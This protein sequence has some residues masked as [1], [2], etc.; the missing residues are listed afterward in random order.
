[1]T[2]ERWQR[3]KEVFQSA[4]ERQPQD[5]GAFLAAETAGDRE[6]RR[7]VE[8]MLRHAS[9]AG[10]LDRPA[11]DGL[12]FD[13]QLAVG[14]R[15]G[16]YEIL[17]EAGAGGMGRVYKA[18]DTRLGRM[19]AI[20]VL[21]AEFSDRFQSEARAISALNHPHVCGLHDIGEQDG[22]AY[23]VMEYVEGE[24]LAAC[25][26]RGPL[27]VEEVLRY[28]EEIAD[29]LAAAHAQGIVH[30]DLKPDNIMIT[31]SGAKVLDFGVARMAGAGTGDPAGETVAGT[32]AYMSPSQ[33]NGNPPDAR[34]DIFALGMVLQDMASGLQESRRPRQPV[35]NL[36]AGLAKLIEGCLEV[37][38]A[39]RIQR[40]EDVRCALERMRSEPPPSRARSLKPVWATVLL[41]VAAA[42]AGLTWRLT[43]PVA[44]PVTISSPAKPRWSQEDEDKVPVSDGRGPASQPA[45]VRGVASLPPAPVAPLTAVV[46]ASY[47]GI[48]R[49]PSFSPDG[50][51]VA[52]SWHPGSGYAYGIYVRPLSTDAEPRS[53]TSGAYE[54]WGPAWSPDGRT[55][56]FRRGGAQPGI[57]R[58]PT[59]G[60]TE[61]LLAPIARQ[62]HET[63]PQMSWS[64][65][66][67]W[68]AAPDRDP[69]GGTQIYLFPTGAG[70]KRKITSNATG[71]D[72]APAFSPDGKWLAYASCMADVSQC[73]VYVLGLGPDAHPKSSRRITERGAYIRGVA[74]LPDSRSLVYA[75]G[76]RA[77]GNTFLWRAALDPPS[78]PRRLDVAGSQVRHPAVS[79]AGG[80]L[81]YTNL[82]NWNLM[83]IENFR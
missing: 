57:Y 61:S 20:K 24:S 66:G 60:G 19:V 46:L 33:L 56:A 16:P 58:V 59:S 76:D 12:R 44:P 47:P 77:S 9:G 62:G 63:L 35:A 14:T 71:T 78:L 37:D 55:I 11:W 79:L 6:L 82:Q 2:V 3:V 75:A 30:R 83:G 27:P 1:V 26:A 64:R 80:L 65:G 32:P 42:G 73:D 69:L 13:S 17:E 22:M 10:L 45:P 41:A 5:R 53:L 8:K 4:A 43:R 52:F 38:A 39:S 31:K 49:D 25:L 18:R 51:K 23:L 68:I 48:K 74:W 15:L 67:K 54:D 40:M 70:E 72:H 28:G 34:G 81:A 36:P 7:E 50:R 29:A 21:N